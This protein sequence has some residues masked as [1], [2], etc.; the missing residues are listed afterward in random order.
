MAF[1]Q[2]VTLAKVI[3]QY[4]DFE[5]NAIAG[6]IT[7]TLDATQRNLAADQIVVPSTVS[8]TIDTDGRFEVELPAT[9]DTDLTPG[10]FTYEVEEVFTGGLSYTISLPALNLNTTRTN[11]APNPSYSSLNWLSTPVNST[12]VISTAYSK[13]GTSSLEL[14]CTVAGEMRNDQYIPN[15]LPSVRYA[16]SVWV[17]M[18]T[19]AAGQTRTLVYEFVETFA[20]GAPVSARSEVGFGTYTAGEGWRKITGVRVMA[21]GTRG[22]LLT[23]QIDNAQIGDVVYFDGLIVEELVSGDAGDYFDGDMYDGTPPIAATTVTITGAVGNGSEVTYTTNTPHNFATG[24][25]LAVSGITPSALNVSGTVIG[26]TANTFTIANTSTAVYTSGGRADIVKWNGVAGVSTSTYPI[27]GGT[28]DISQYRATATNADPKVQLVGSLQWNNLTT[29]LNAQDAIINQSDNSLNYNPPENHHLFPKYLTYQNFYDEFYSSPRYNLVANPS[30]EVDLTGWVAANSCTAAR[31]TTDAI[32]GSACAEMTMTA[33][34]N[35]NGL[36]IPVAE[37]FAVTVGETFTVS[38]FFKNTV[39]TR[40]SRVTVLYWNAAGVFVSDSN[41]NVLINPT[42]WQRSSVIATV[43]ANAVTASIYLQNTNTGSIGDKILVDAVLREKTATVG[44]YFDGSMDP[45]T[46]W[47]GTANNSIST[48]IQR[49]RVNYIKNPSFVVDTTGWTAID[50]GVT[51]SRST[52]ENLFGTTGS[53]SIVSADVATGSGAELTR[54]SSYR[55]PVTEGGVLTGSAY[56]KQG[57][58]TRTYQVQLDFYTTATGTTPISS[59]TS[60]GPTLSSAWTRY[61][62]SGTVPAGAAFASLS[63]RRT[64][65]GSI[66]DSCFVDGV[67]LE[68]SS[69]LLR[70][71]FDGSV[72]DE[73]LIDTTLNSHSK[74]DA[75]VGTAHDSY[76]TNLNYRYNYIRNNNFETGLDHWTLSS[77]NTPISLYTLD[78]YRGSQCM[79]ITAVPSSGTTG[80]GARVVLTGPPQGAIPVRR[81][82]ILTASCYVK[83]LVGTRNLAIYFVW[84][85]ALG[86]GVI[87]STGG[88]VVNPTT[89]TKVSVTGTVP[90]G[91]IFAGVW[92][93]FDST[94]PAGD[95][96]L[97]DE[98]W[99]E[100]VNTEQPYFN[101]DFQ[102]TWEGT[103]EATF[104]ITNTYGALQTTNVSIS[105]TDIDDLDTYVS[106]LA[107]SAQGLKTFNPLFLTV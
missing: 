94:G 102:G 43:P 34:T 50:A 59:V 86:S 90:A 17:N 23:P 33:I 2:N 49:Y 52:A 67:L 82:E 42:T 18:P 64:S 75:W 53:L 73:G 103:R 5:G 38:A 98:V 32:S 36:S 58:G 92:I 70:P 65:T 54:T 45:N 96:F 66:S 80:N 1:A 39:G 107:D 10:G 20:D 24:L 71:Y 48:R 13:Y 77:A 87:S 19:L 74:Y 69:N 8:A 27:Y 4:V 56:L 72:N 101:G 61:S 83:N 105:P 7:F 37:R 62:I 78:A 3:G 29:T 99:C 60:A 95:S 91:A 26:R 51:I 79:R 41:G 15:L 16:F 30:F 22:L 104:S 100:R 28:Y 44:T 93:T 68:R 55:L 85:S 14:T 84:Y 76:S 81:Q 47:V 25:P 57:V 40:N 63:I 6:Q 11:L 31:I 21:A 106:N 97:A 12:S 35:D 89:W 9:D 46:S 88:Q